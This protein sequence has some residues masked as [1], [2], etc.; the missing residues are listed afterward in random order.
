M[1]EEDKNCYNCKNCETYDEGEGYGFVLLCEK[2]CMNTDGYFDYELPLSKDKV[3]FRFLTHKDYI[4]LKK[5][6]DLEV[7]SL[8]KAEIEKYNDKLEY[9]LGEDETLTIAERK[10][11]TNIGRYIRII[12]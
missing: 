8:R 5:L 2:D 12:N 9:Y 4:N 10:D 7:A 3:K 11:I 6:D 1:T